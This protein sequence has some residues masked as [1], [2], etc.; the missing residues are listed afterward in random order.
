MEWIEF[1]E[2][3]PKE[4]DFYFVKGKVGRKAVMYYDA[5]DDE[6]EIG[7]LA[8]NHFCDSEIYWLNES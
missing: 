3:K 8:H 7:N 6:W 4:T 1:S 5:F 2:E